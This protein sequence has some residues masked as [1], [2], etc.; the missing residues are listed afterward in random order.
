MFRLGV[1]SNKGCAPLHSS[2]FNPDEGAI[3]VGIKVIT[4][5]IVNLNKQEREIL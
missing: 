5:T 4:E 1:S 2:Q 3:A